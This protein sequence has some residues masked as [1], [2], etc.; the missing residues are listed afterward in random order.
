MEVGRNLT[1]EL[2]VEASQ[3]DATERKDGEEVDTTDVVIL[4]YDQEVNRLYSHK[5]TTSLYSL[6][7]F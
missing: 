3:V 1:P 6:T 7:N 4:N 2:A 5:H